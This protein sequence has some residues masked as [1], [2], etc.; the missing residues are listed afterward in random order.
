VH[1]KAVYTA[2]S[3]STWPLWLAQDAGLLAKYGIDAELEYVVSSTTALQ[4]LLSGE[5]A[6][7]PT[8]SAPSVVQA[9]LG[10]GDAV[11]VGATNNTV[12]FSLMAA[13]DI[14]QYADLR[15]RRLGISRLGSSSDSAARS[16]L[17]KWGLKP[18]ADVTI[19]QMGGIPEILAGMQAGA[20]EAGVLSSPTDL[21]AEQAGFHQLADL[22]AIGIDYPQTAIATT[23]RYLQGNEDVARRFLRATVEAVHLMKTDPAR[24]QTIFGKYTDT[25]DPEVLEATYRAYV[26]KT[27]AV[28]YARPA[29][30]QVAIDEVAQTDPR[31]A[32]AKVEDF[33]DNHYVQELEA[34]GFIQQL[35]GR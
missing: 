13:P 7:I 35:Y 1:I 5:V 25:S 28:P 17:T 3:G 34:S 26:D 32:T 22:G 11:I 23:R 20:V 10:G 24:A 33:V 30:M 4:S 2:L 27:D 8:A 16:A 15:G 14:Q 18:D 29:A 12:V 6:F 9:A 21:R 31:A 19:V